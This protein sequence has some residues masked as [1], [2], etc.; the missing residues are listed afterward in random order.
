MAKAN[1][2]APGIDAMNFEAI[3]QAG[4]NAFLQQ[5]QDEL[6]SEMYQPQ[7]NR[8]KE[9]PKA[10]GKTRKL[11]IPTI[12][13]R[14]VQNALK[15]ILEPVFEADFQDGS[16]G[17]RPKR[18]P[19]Q[20]LE[21]VKE[22]A[23]KGL[24]RTIELDLQSYFDTVKHHILLKK[25][26]IRVND[27]K[28]M[29]LLNLILKAGGKEGVPQG[30]TLSPLLSNIYLNEVDIMLEKA[31]AVTKQG[32]YFQME[33]TRFADDLCIQVSGH[34][35]QDWLWKGLNKR[36]REELSKLEV[37]INEQK[38]TYPDLTKGERF[39][40]MGFTIKRARSMN[41]KWM[42]LCMPKK[43]ARSRLIGELREVFRSHRSRP[44]TQVRDK[45]NPI[46]RGWVNY[47][48]I[49]H[50]TKVF[51]A[52]QQ[53]LIRKIRRHIMRAK[54]KRGCGW[55]QWSNEG[56]IAVFNIYNDYSVARTKVVPER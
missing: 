35:T 17:Y 19:Q 6:G 33:Y 45:I 13:D 56:L 31:R 18:S 42:S 7:R 22:A 46:L 8:I 53:W 25:V 41:G 9:I 15:L 3:E 38:T 36:V 24:T 20:A 2:G 29:R 44:M 54:G 49:G 1:N 28:V 30:G 26:A 43:E 12:R 51:R 21:R 14:V 52:V 23:A 10:N 5:L 50:S 4:V 39:N 48:R 11:G 37:K 40:F 27:D 55:K 32:V 16:F 34:W 47:Y